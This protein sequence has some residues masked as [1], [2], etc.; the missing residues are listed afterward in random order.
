MQQWE[1]NNY[2]GQLQVASCRSDRS[3]LML[4]AASPGGHGTRGAGIDSEPIPDST[5][6]SG[7][8]SRQGIQEHVGLKDQNTQTRP[9]IVGGRGRGLSV[10][11]V[12]G[13][14]RILVRNGKERAFLDTTRTSSLTGKSKRT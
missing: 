7:A 14:E 12:D 2:Q 1:H 13:Q 5:M 4:L 3:L 9:L 8:I 11:G 6:D 10:G